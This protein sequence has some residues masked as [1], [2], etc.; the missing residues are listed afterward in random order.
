MDEQNSTPT[1][2]CTK[3]GV[4]KP[5]SEYHKHSIQKSGLSPSCKACKKINS[6]AYRAANP[7]KLK[8][9]TAAWAAANP[10]R[11]RK[12]KQ[13]WRALNRDKVN[14]E[15]A[16]YRAANPEKVK[17]A[18]LAR[19]RDNPEREKARSAAY[20]A[21]NR[22]KIQAYAVAFR[23]ANPERV[24]ATSA[25]WRDANRDRVRE[26]SADWRKRNPDAVRVST[27]NRRA[28]VQKDGGVLSKG[29]AKRLFEMQKGKCPCCKQP[30]GKS[31]HLDHKMPLALGGT[32]TDDNMQLLR[33][34]CNLNKAA[35]HPVD[36]MQS[37]GYLI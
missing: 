28:L 19:Y 30:L 7:E 37:R 15:T 27:Q 6:D 24:L 2:I 22:E 4:E 16:A 5:V 3:C 29:L 18:Q 36:F 10:E 17:A 1:K 21:A 26:I 13:A 35:K 20:K 34:T 23:E 31:Y 8:A 9:A 32:N 14:A 33:A 11:R 25:R 12:N